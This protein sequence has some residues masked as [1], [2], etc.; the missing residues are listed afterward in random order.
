[1]IKNVIFDIG[2]V[3]V[4]YQWKP[5]LNTFDFDET[6]YT[7]IEKAVFL[8]PDWILGDMGILSTEEWIWRLI[9]SDPELEPQIRQVFTGIGAVITRYP[10]TDAWIRHFRAQGYRIYYLSNFPDE[11]YRQAYEELRFL[12]EFDGGI[13]SWKVKCVKPDP[14]IYQMLFER[15]HLK[16]EECIYYDDTA[17]NIEAAKKLG[18]D[19]VLFQQDIALQMLQK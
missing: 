9:A 17:V 11:V 14:Q 18:M 15:Y 10:Y 1:M 6:T 13:F 2:K 5:Y 7:R 16:P 4:D 8:N 3:L 12:D 19:A